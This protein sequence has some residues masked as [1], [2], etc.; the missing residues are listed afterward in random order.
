[1][2][3]HAA[4]D[5]P[6]GSAAGIDPLDAHLP[7]RGD[8]PEL[9]VVVDATRHAEERIDRARHADGRQR[10]QP[11]GHAVAGERGAHDIRIHPV[12]RRAPRPVHRVAGLGGGLREHLAREDEG[13]RVGVRRAKAGAALVSDGADVCGAAHGD[14]GTRRGGGICGGDLSAVRRRRVAAV[15]RVGDGR[16]GRRAGD[17]DILRRGVKAALRQE[18]GVGDEA[19][20]ARG[21]RQAGRRRVHIDVGRRRGGRAAQLGIEEEIRAAR[22]VVQRVDGEDVAAIAEQRHA[23]AD[24]DRLEDGGAVR[25]AIRGGRRIE[26]GHRRSIAARDF[27]AIDIRHKAIVVA[28]AE[29]RLIEWHRTIHREGIAGVER[30]IHGPHR[31]LDIRRDVRRK[32]GELHRAGACGERRDGRGIQRLAP[33]RH[34]VDLA[35]VELA[36]AGVVREADH[37]RVLPVEVR[38]RLHAR[39]HERAVHI[40]PLP[41]HAAAED[42][43]DVVPLV[44]RVVHSGRRE[45]LGVPGAHAHVSTREIEVP[46]MA[47]RAEDPRADRVKSGRR[48]GR[49]K[50]ERRRVSRLGDI[51]RRARVG[52]AGA[53]EVQRFPL[54]DRARHGG[55]VSRTRQRC[56]RSSGDR[57]VRRVVE[58]P[59]RDRQPWPRAAGLVAEPRRGRGPRRVGEAGRRP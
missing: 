1:M 30:R 52:A 46:V 28:H 19:G 48:R 7:L 33:D 51:Q 5:V 50:P 17:R 43:R 26:R 4:L 8:A 38:L 6:A 35:L 25:T 41:A 24:V 40:H 57:V 11:V 20:E 9:R 29:R 13:V 55:V 14:S 49:A 16:A 44:V 10:E 21:V 32:A 54:A 27:H 18:D 31:R 47:G 39:E 59:I 37:H 22:G 36:R 34:V 56:L 23:R 12:I 2:Q 53:G 58:G 3:A 15:E 45:R 42:M